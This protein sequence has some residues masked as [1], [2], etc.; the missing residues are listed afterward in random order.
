MM[1]GRPG[2]LGTPAK[3]ELDPKT[4]SPDGNPTPTACRKNRNPNWCQM[5]KVVI[6]F[7]VLPKR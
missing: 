4:T 5:S 6:H 2:A 7:I 1:S 3:T